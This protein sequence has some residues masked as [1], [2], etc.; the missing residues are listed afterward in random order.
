MFRLEA[1]NELKGEETMEDVN[2]SF[3]EMFSKVFKRKG[4]EEE[5]EFEEEI[6]DMLQEGHEQG[7][8]PSDE[9]EMISNI[10]EF[11][12]KE[13]RDVMTIRKKIKAIEIHT[14]LK[15]ALMFM[16]EE[17][18]SRYPLY[19]DNLDNIVGILHLKDTMKAYIAEDGD[20]PLKKLAREASFVHE[21]QKINSLFKEMQTKK[22]H[23]VIVLDEYGQTEGIVVMEDILEVIVGNIWDED[24]EE[25]QGI[26]KIGENTYRIFGWTRLDE[27][28]DV[29]EI[30]FPEDDIGTINGFLLYQLGHLPKED[31]KIEIEYKGYYFY[32]EIVDNKMIK[33]VKVM[34]RLDPVLE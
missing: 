3:K 15:D 6:I 20:V 23:M 16:L 7:V 5:N 4:T 14:S 25:E 31:E 2:N 29:L 33:Q 18:Y 8:I 32:P 34:K 10:F 27:I 21:T 24:D 19:E 22:I 1:R 26:V 30:V 12:D 11:G 17:G 9:A 28:E 13:A